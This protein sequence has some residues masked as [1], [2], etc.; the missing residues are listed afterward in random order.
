MCMS[1]LCQLEVDY[2]LQCIQKRLMTG[3]R[4]SHLF[5]H[6]KMGIKPQTSQRFI[7]KAIL[8]TARRSGTSS[9]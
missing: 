9:V 2:I 1:R 8:N 4:H 6:V 5:L 7:R 3:C